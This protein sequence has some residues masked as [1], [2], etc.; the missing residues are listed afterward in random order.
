MSK[1]KGLSPEDAAKRLQGM[2]SLGIPDTNFS[3]TPTPNV[4]MSEPKTKTETETETAT[5][6]A[7][8]P[9][10]KSAPEPTPE[11]AEKKEVEKA[12]VE[13][14]PRET[15]VR[16]K[17]KEQPEN[18][19]EIYFRR[20]DFSDRQ[21]LYITRS[22]HEKLMMIVSI[23]GGRKATISSYV[24]NVLMQ[25]FDSHREEINRLFDEY[26]HKNKI[27]L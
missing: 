8:E 10:P 22:T 19:R 9:V 12:E 13:N 15:P 11:A 17:R 6:I 4:T 21:P 2:V 5:E 25:H 24:E 3:A 14:P 20:I 16:K 23:I 26:Y 1:T 7:P 27:E 18:Y